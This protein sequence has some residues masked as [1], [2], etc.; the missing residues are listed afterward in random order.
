MENP[1]NLRHLRAKNSTCNH[2]NT[3]DFITQTDTIIQRIG[4]QRSNVIPLLQAIQNEFALKK[5]L[6][7][8]LS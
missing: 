4:T 3:S 6:N 5:V 8:G 2:N 1:D 7:K